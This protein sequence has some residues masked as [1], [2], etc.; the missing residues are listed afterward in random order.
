MTLSV[1][2][3]MSQTQFES[4]RCVAAHIVSI[5]ARTKDNYEERG[6]KIPINHLQGGSLRAN[7]ERQRTEKLAS[8]TRFRFCHC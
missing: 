5:P 3:G 6:K 4:M 8:A 1:L 7:E 2:P